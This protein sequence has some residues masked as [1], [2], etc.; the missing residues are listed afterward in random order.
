MTLFFNATL[1]DCTGKEPRFPAW[2]LT[3]GGDIKEIGFSHTPPNVQAAEKVDCKGMILMPGLIDAHM[4]AS[5]Y[6]NTSVEK[7]RRYFP[8]MR[9]MKAFKVLEDTLF[10]GFTTVRDCGGVDAGFREAINCGLAI[11]PRMTVC[12][13][14]LT[15]TGGH[16]DHRLS[17]EIREPIDDP[18]EGVVCDG[19]NEVRKMAREQLRT[20]ADHIKLMT[21]GGCSSE[22]DEPESSQ[23]S[24]EEIK[25]AVEEAEAA[26]KDTIG[27]CY[28]NRSMALCANA[29][30]YSIEHGNFL[31][32]K[33]ATLIKEK[34]CWLVPT[35]STYYIMSR[36]GDSMGFPDYFMRKM[37][38]VADHAFE[39]LDIAY[40]AKLKIASGSDLVGDCQPFKGTELEMKAKIM[41]LMDALLTMTK[42]NAE[43]LKK[44]DK[45]G[46]LEEGKFADIILV[47]GD[48]LKDPKV[49]QNRDNIRVI[50]KNGEFFKK[51]I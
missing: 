22:S 37:K 35:I 47:D 6:Q 11:G 34:G 30:V 36:K 51:N 49:L 43:L 14:I 48:L 19:V 16:A 17:V 20:G 15:M 24:L 32:E 45:L 3:E 23:F 41:P 2:L 40:K 29:G 44:E 28:S 25:A 13:H 4:H 21:G 12:N 50:M 18:L 1:L 8:G 42:N 39:A 7:S 5:S 27:H 38:Y 9:Y 10:Q 46:T 31:D 33:T 26:G